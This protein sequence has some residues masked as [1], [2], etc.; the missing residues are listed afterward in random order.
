MNDDPEAGAEEVEELIAKTGLRG[1]SAV[2]FR[3]ALS[4][5]SSKGSGGGG[6]GGGGGKKGSKGGGQGKKPAV[7]KPK[8]RWPSLTSAHQWQI[9]RRVARRRSRNDQKS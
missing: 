3:R 2:K 5:P 4:K 6:G 8:R 9:P 7:K 1:G